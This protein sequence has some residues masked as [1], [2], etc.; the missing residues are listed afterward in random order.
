MQMLTVNALFILSRPFK[1]MSGLFLWIQ[2]V[3]FFL[4]YMAYS[5]K[6]YH[7]VVYLT[8]VSGMWISMCNK[9]IWA[10]KDDEWNVWN[11]MYLMYR[12]CIK[13]HFLEEV[14]KQSQFNTDVSLWPTQANK[15]ISKKIN[16]FYSVFLIACHQS[17]WARVYIFPGKVT[18]SWMLAIHKATEWDFSLDN[19]F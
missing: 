9:Q 14:M 16:Y 19:S 7:S 17:G 10:Q 6:P 15:T 1:M 3:F 2:I 12:L 18:V 11:L 8:N 5:H 4:F 13:I